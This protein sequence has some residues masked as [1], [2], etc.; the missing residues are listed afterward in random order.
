VHCV[1]LLC[2][3]VMGRYIAGVDKSQR[4]RYI[5]SYIVLSWWTLKLSICR[6]IFLNIAMLM[7]YHDIFAVRLTGLSRRVYDI[8]VRSQIQIQIQNKNL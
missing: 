3:L 4:Y 7:K 8:S 2:P 6:E 1:L 5:V